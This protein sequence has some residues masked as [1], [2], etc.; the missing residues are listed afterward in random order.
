[1]PDAVMLVAYPAVKPLNAKGYVTRLYAMTDTV[2]TLVP[3]AVATVTEWSAAQ[4]NATPAVTSAGQDLGGVDVTAPTLATVAAET[5]SPDVRR[6]VSGGGGI[7]QDLGRIDVT[8][9]VPT[10]VT[11]EAASAAIRGV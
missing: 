8:A 2:V 9:P 6:T 1:M 4:W 3:D 11:T 5:A 10:T 7:A